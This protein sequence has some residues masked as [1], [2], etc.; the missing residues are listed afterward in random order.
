MNFKLFEYSNK[1]VPFLKKDLAFRAS[2]AVL[3]FA[4]FAI[5]LIS[6]LQNMVTNNINLGKIISSVIV[7]STCCLFCFLSILYMIKTQRTIEIINK[8][9]KCVSSVNLLFK[10]DKDSFVKL[11]YIVCYALSLLA[12]LVFVC[13]LTYSILQVKYYASTSFYLPLLATIVL[14]SYYSV[15]HI[16]NEIKIMQ[17]VNRYHSIY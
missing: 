10:I 17:T 12:T 8:S 9:G 14:T 4:V 6:T 15:L 5:Q 1:D 16:K 13:S 11:Y 3:F 2:F 7:I